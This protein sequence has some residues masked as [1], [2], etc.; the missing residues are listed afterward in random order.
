MA[1]RN[2][3]TQYHTLPHNGGD[4]SKSYT[5]EFGYSSSASSSPVPPM[6]DGLLRNP[7]HTRFCAQAKDRFVVRIVKI[8]DK[9]AASRGTQPPPPPP[10]PNRPL[11][12]VLHDPQ[13]MLKLEALLMQSA[14][15]AAV[16]IGFQAQLPAMAAE[17]VSRSTSA[18]QVN[19]LEG[20][21]IYRRRRLGKGVRL[22]FSCPLRGGGLK[23]NDFA[24]GTVSQRL[25]SWETSSGRR[26]ILQEVLQALK[27]TVELLL[28]QIRRDGLR[29][30]KP[31]IDYIFYPVPP[32]KNLLGGK[33]TDQPAQ[34]IT[35]PVFQYQQN[36]FAPPAVTS[37]RPVSAHAV[38]VGGSSSAERKIL[39]S[40]AQNLA[41]SISP[42]DSPVMQTAEHI[43]LEARASPIAST[44][45]VSAESPSDRIS[46]A[47]FIGTSSSPPTWPL[48]LPSPLHQPPAV[49]GEAEYLLSG[50]EGIS[51]AQPPP[52]ST[53]A[54]YD[55]SCNDMVRRISPSM[56]TG[57]DMMTTL[58]T[59]VVDRLR[60][61]PHLPLIV[62]PSQTPRIP[63]LVFQLPSPELI[64]VGLPATTSSSGHER[65]RLV[66]SPADNTAF[67][68]TSKR[69]P[70]SCLPKMNYLPGAT[71]TSRF[72]VAAPRPGHILGV[73]S[74]GD[75]LEL[76]A[77][78]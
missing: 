54:A 14:S 70:K 5:L 33:F 25:E 49:G 22:C 11:R 55:A 75:I 48:H 44:C 43:P 66:T 51:L 9:S 29:T 50:I 34:Q 30:I 26:G 46:S 41:N 20:M 10:S 15:C 76:Q 42:R 68:V 58:I 35:P 37:G 71:D 77:G 24:L 74:E 61:S 17:Y 23:L 21:H 6:S 62:M 56:P 69:R 3:P 63:P 13:E 64:F 38:V 72:T 67:V 53:V 4:L 27:T 2:S 57:E 36:P 39:F 60:K 78:R 31:E 28:A 73:S 32:Y 8:T 65:P 45:Y 52:P 1:M 16:F 59:E 19:S 47:P 18:D 40:P 7:Q 12:A